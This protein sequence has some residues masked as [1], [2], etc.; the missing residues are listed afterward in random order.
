MFTYA[1]TKS[2][3][4]VL[5]VSETKYRGFSSSLIIQ[6]AGLLIRLRAQFLYSLYGFE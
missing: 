2:N 4:N 5:I 6:L 1:I 3:S